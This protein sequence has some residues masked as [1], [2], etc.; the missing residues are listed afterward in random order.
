MLLWVNAQHFVIVSECLKQLHLDLSA[1]FGHFN[2]IFDWQNYES[3]SLYVESI[4]KVY[5]CLLIQP[6]IE[7]LRILL[8][9]DRHYERVLDSIFK[10]NKIF[11]SHAYSHKLDLLKIYWE[12]IDMF[13]SPQNKIVLNKKFHVT[14]IRSI[15]LNLV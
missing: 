3:L 13:F 14:N 10:P 6:F 9:L 7:Y 15:N 11:K 12:N 8:L 2:E 4:L 1:I 5:A